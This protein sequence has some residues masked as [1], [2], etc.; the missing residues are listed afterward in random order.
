ML[1]DTLNQIIKYLSDFDINKDSSYLIYLDENALYSWAMSEPLPTGRFKWLKEDKWDDIFKNREGIGYFI[2]CDLEYPKE[3]HYLHN[4]YPLAP[5]KLIV[6]DDWLSPFGKNLKEKFGLASDKTTKLIPT[7]FNKEKYVLHIRK[8]SLY[9]DF[10][11]KLTK[12]H[13]ALQFN[14]SLWLPK[15]IDLNT[16]KGKKQKLILKK[17]I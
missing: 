9:K 13:I 2:E 6:Q 14:E 3:L 4:D 15:Y 10:G 11:M 8:L 1:I 16:K 12:S 5:E 17:I 7:L